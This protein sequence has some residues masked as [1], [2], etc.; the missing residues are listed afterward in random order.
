M[1]KIEIDLNNANADASNLSIFEDE[2]RILMELHKHPGTKPVT[3]ALSDNKGHK[4]E[5]TSIDE[6]YVRCPKNYYDMLEIHSRFIPNEWIKGIIYIG[7]W[8]EILTIDVSLNLHLLYQNYADPNRIM[9]Q[10]GYSD[11]ANLIVE[12]DTDG[13]YQLIKTLMLR[14]TS[15]VYHDIA[16]A[17][18]QT[19]IELQRIYNEVLNNQ[20]SATYKSKAFAQ[21]QYTIDLLKKY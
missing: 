18:T 5:F 3:Y 12:Q 8:A 7:S 16:F 14:P 2:E 17:G 13:N 9:F 15:E 21:A 4:K 10:I 1:R 6:M 19:A 11:A 20:N